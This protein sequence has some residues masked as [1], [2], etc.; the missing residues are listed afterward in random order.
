VGLA[1]TP[2]RRRWVILAVLCLGQFAVVVDNTVLN[3]AVPSLTRDL[4]AA[5]ADVQWMINAYSLVQCGLLLAVGS[6]ADR[7][8]R[9]RL[10]LAGLAIFGAG[11]LAAG[12]AQSTGQLIASRA[13][14]GVGGALLGTATL[15]VTMQVFD[16]KQRPRAI[17]IWAATNALGF[18]A[19][20]P[21]GGLLLANFWWGSIFLVNI[22]VVIIALVGVRT[23]VPE[24]RNLVGGRPDLLGALLSTA[25]MTAVVYSIISGPDHGLL[26]VRVIVA[27]LSGVLLL[28]SFAAWERRIPNPMLDMQFFRNQR[29][30]GAVA[31]IAL[32]TFGSAGV[33]FL[34]TQQ[35]QLIRGYT[36]L[37][38]GLRMAPFALTVVVL[39]FSGVS[40]SLMRRL[41]LPNAIAV[42]MALLAGGF[43]VVASLPADSHGGLLPGL[44]LMGAGCALA[45]PAIVEAVMSAIPQDKAGAGAGIDGTMAEVGSS[46]GVAVLGAV[47]NARFAAMLPTAAAGAGSVPAALS[48]ARTDTDRAAVLHA[49][50]SGVH[51]SQLVG[52]AAVFLGGCVTAVLL[53]RA[54]RNEAVGPPA[55]SRV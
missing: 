35:L 42:G 34:L 4:G 17:G 45:N 3:V 7:Y 41:G 18:A 36:P 29:F 46:L 23:L 43:T 24:S 39:T 27:A 47:M 30:V 33:L 25:G 54:E 20:P 51:T 12:L 19:G 53:Y 44:V 52:A 31:G 55:P 40:A 15:A 22:P 49:F 11:S 50:A 6:A 13:G 2:L 1:R 21:I 37:E 9:K 8:G 10:L 14:M 32:I 16:A 28:A 38:A 26:S 5:T 48:M